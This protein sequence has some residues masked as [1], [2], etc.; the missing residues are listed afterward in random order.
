MQLLELLIS[1]V[2]VC[3]LLYIYIIYLQIAN[4]EHGKSEN[5]MI[6]EMKKAPRPPQAIIDGY[7]Y[8]NFWYQYYSS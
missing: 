6:N 4:G 2:V 1:F 8:L 5:P 7:K 3:L